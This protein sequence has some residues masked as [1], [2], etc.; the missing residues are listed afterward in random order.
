ML[1]RDVNG[2]QAI[3]SELQ[4]FVTEVVGVPIEPGQKFVARESDFLRP[5]V[6]VGGFAG[7]LEQDEIEQFFVRA[8]QPISRRGRDVPTRADEPPVRQ[9][10]RRFGQQFV[11]ALTTGGL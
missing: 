3:E 7:E 10:S 1:R 4:L 9:S 5:I 2:A 6:S 8:G 11:F